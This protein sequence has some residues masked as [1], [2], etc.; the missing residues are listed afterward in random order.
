M[1]KMKA[2]KVKVVLGVTVIALSIF[3]G[4]DAMEDFLNPLKY[5]KEVTSEPNKFIGRNIQVVGWI[6]EGSWRNGNEPGQYFFA[7]SDGEA[8]INVDYTG[9]PPGTLK[10]GVGV[11]VIGTMTSKD[12]LVSNKLLVKCPSKYEQ[13]LKEAYAAQTQKNA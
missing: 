9:D 11:T 6:V 13:T 2:K 4:V 1:D 5:V 3:L 7:L 8:T 10:S 12:T